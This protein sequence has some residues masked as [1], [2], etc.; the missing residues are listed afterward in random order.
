MHQNY[1]E[2]YN[3][4]LYIVKIKLVAAILINESTHNYMSVKS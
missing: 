2:I 1:V 4:K 3:F